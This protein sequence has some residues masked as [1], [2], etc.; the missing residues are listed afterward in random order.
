MSDLKKKILFAFSSIPDQ[1]PYQMFT[2]LVFLYYFSIIGMYIFE[3]WIIFIIWAVWNAINDP[4]LGS[5]SDRTRTKFGRRRLFITIS[6]IPLCI[7]TVLLFT[8]P[9]W[10]NSYPL[11]VIYFAIMIMLFEFI[12]TMYSVNVN[13][14]FPEMFPTEEE[15]AKTNIW[16]KGFTVFALVFAFAGPQLFITPLLP[17]ETTPASVVATLPF[18]YI[19]F[20]IMAAIVMGIMAAPFIF[21]GIKE[22]KTETKA[23]AEKRPTFLQSMKIT[24]KNKTFLIFVGANMMIWYIF[25]ILPTVLPYYGT[26]VLGITAKDQFLIIGVPLILALL[27]AVACFPLHKYIGKKLGMRN[28]LI[29][30]CCVWGLTLLPYA[31]IF[32]DPLGIIRFLAIFVTISQGFGLAG[33]MYYVDIIISNIIDEDEVKTTGVRREGSY[34]GMNAFIHRLSIIL[35]ISSIFLIFNSTGWAVYDPWSTNPFIIQAGI[36]ML[37]VGFPVI[38]ICIAVVLLLVFPLHGKRLEEVQKKIEELRVK[39]PE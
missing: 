12:Y 10:L 34:Y 15:R 18:Q 25:G 38:A 20:G 1:L 5:L 8:V 21:F 2:Y 35:K 19:L 23:E 16:I 22:R 7:I 39:K 3:M 33:A 11:I 13:A 6:I 31:F 17:A 32:N 4:L 14:L 29:L 9:Y 36:K 28:G 26:H 27:F 30:T 37:I 24:L